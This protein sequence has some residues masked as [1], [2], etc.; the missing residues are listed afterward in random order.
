[1]NQIQNKSVYL[2]APKRLLNSDLYT[3]ASKFIMEQN[4]VGLLN[5]RGLFE[6]NDQWFNHYD[7]YLIACNVIVIVSDNAIV[8]KGCYTEFQHFK[9]RDCKAYHYIET[10]KTKTLIEIKKL[11]IIND[12]N[13][14]DYAVIKYN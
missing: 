6:S 7:E 10:G 11:Q 5:A 9:D 1:M 3:R 8:G 13:W 14:I 2:A 12:D 4:P